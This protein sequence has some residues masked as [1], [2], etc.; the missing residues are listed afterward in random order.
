ML[1][2]S[3]KS[4]MLSVVSLFIEHKFFFTAKPELTKRHRRCLEPLRD[5]DNL[6][7]SEV[8]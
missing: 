4:I 2:F 6:D 8:S 7:N 5:D 1:S 3:I